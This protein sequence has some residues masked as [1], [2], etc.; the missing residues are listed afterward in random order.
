MA[1]RVGAALLMVA[2]AACGGGG[3]EEAAESG[4]AQGSQFR[5]YA[6]AHPATTGAAQ[7]PAATTLTAAQTD[8]LARL[9]RRFAVLAMEGGAVS[10]QDNALSLPPLHFARQSL[11]AAAAHGDTLAALQR[12]VTLPSSPA[13]AAGLMQ[14]V[15]RTVSAVD[16]ARFKPDFLRATTAEGYAGTWEL[17]SLLPLTA[18]QLSSNGNLR[19]LVTDQL[20]WQAPWPRATSARGIWVAAGAKRDVPMV[21]IQGSVL[22]H[23]TADYRAT[24]LAMPGGEWLI[25]ITPPSRVLLAP[26]A[27][28]AAL[29]QVHVA[30]AQR[31]LSAASDG[32][33]VLPLMGLGNTVDAG[34]L[35]GMAAAMDPAKAD[36]RGLD[37]GGTYLTTSPTHGTLSIAPGGLELSGGLRTQFEFNAQNPFAGGSSTT[38]VTGSF[39]TDAGLPP[40][41]ADALDLTPFHLVLMRP[42][43]SIVFLARAAQFGGSSCQ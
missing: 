21:R 23:D 41:P 2:L 20:Q 32:E 33:L 3:G 6:L 7:T 12:A 29:A 10:P 35:A 31:P 42:N 27:L 5:A 26:A 16:Q 36:L 14:G 4:A 30:I 43:G 28:D 24:G 15:R 40:C 39:F 8:E 34:S 17:L 38:N 13:V 9:S 25:R 11:V 18:T 19:M 22:Q 37:A 1:T